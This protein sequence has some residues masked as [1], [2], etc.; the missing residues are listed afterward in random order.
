MLRKV[1]FLALVAMFVVA[2]PSSAQV[3]TSALSGVVT[4]ENR[5]AMIAATIS[6]QPRSPVTK[7]NI[8][9]NYFDEYKKKYSKEISQAIHLQTNNNVDGNT[10]MVSESNVVLF[11]FVIL[12]ALFCVAVVIVVA[13]CMGNSIKF[14]Y[15]KSGID[16]EIF[17]KK[18]KRE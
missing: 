9:F 1:K 10:G 17:S 11:S 12:L 13:L 3:T 14:K 15:N 16:F 8:F 18:A 4:N 5:Q 2:L 7:C 6:A